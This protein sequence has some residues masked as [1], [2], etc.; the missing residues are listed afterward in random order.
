[1][2]GN[3]TMRA[4]P[5][6]ELKKTKRKTAAQKK[7]TP[8]RKTKEGEIKIPAGVGFGRVKPKNGKKRAT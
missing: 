5:K 3:L 2:K 1:M 8:K 6:K 7:A 4:I